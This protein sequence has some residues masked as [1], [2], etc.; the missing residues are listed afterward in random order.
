MCVYIHNIYIYVYVYTKKIYTYIH[1]IYI[2]ILCFYLFMC[3]YIYIYIRTYYT[4]VVIFCIYIHIYRAPSPAGAPGASDTRASPARPNCER[5]G[6]GFAELGHPRTAWTPQPRER[7]EGSAPHQSSKGGGVLSLG[8]SLSSWL[9]FG[10][11]WNLAEWTPKTLRHPY[12]SSRSQIV[13]QYDP[14][15]KNLVTRCPMR[16]PL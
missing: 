11:R 5:L 10:L 13:N 2:Y 12:S 14:F 7:A 6:S 3:I 9:R 15:S 1:I 4:D 16:R 8:L